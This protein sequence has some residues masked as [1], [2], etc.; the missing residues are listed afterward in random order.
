[1]KK[2]NCLTERQKTEIDALATMTED[3]I[4]KDDIPEILDR[5]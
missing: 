2:S 1:M 4:R 5:S 3:E